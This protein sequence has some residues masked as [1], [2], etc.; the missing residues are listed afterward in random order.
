MVTRSDVVRF[1]SLYGFWI[2]LSWRLDL[3]FYVLGAL[4]AAA[5]T[6]AFSAVNRSVLASER[7][8][9]PTRLMPLVPL[10]GAAF[11]VWLVGR[12]VVAALQVARAVLD[13]KLPIDPRSLRFRTDLHSPIART[14]LAH[15][16]TL[17]PGT[18]TVELDGDV[19]TVHAMFP[20]AADGLVS[21]ELQSRIAR[22]FFE[23][24]QPAPEVTWVTGPE[25]LP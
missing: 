6:A 11:V 15:S 3:L 20:D 10:R 16:I 23:D 5:V 12:V 13:P 1:C 21:G 14:V 19:L 22:I 17:T 8:G 18:V 4:A 24:P 9:T 7:A 25:V 2:V